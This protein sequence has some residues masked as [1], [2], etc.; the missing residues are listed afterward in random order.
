M[1]PSIVQAHVPVHPHL[2]ALCVITTTPVTTPDTLLATP[3]PAPQPPE[4]AAP[5]PLHNP[6]Q[7]PVLEL[8]LLYTLLT[9]TTLH[10][11]HAPTLWLQQGENLASAGSR[12]S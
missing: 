6:Q 12:E 5:P 3:T 2:P 11:P 1:C 8:Q 9:S 7:P 10:H 4:G